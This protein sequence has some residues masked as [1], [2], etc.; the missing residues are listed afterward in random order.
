MPTRFL[1]PSVLFL[2]T[3]CVSSPEPEVRYPLEAHEDKPY[4]KV[5]EA[6]SVQYDVVHNFETKF[7][8]HITRVT[9]AFR[10][11]LTQRYQHIWN[12]PQPLITEAAQKTA[13]FVTLYTANKDLENIADTAVWNIQL[14][15]AGQTL[16]PTLVKKLKP[17]ERWKP[18]F[19]EINHWSLEFLI[20]FDREAGA[21]T[22]P[23]KLTLSSPDGSVSA[24]W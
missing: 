7:K 1:I 4:F 6:A 21:G 22:E 17:K 9:P 8:A 3:A 2:M 19:P 24:E 12:E 14:Q 13:F 18:F 10:E 23:L 5:F 11:A 16:K 20:L 15:I